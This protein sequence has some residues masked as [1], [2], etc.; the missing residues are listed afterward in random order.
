M[1]EIDFIMQ[2]VK[3]YF[4]EKFSEL[5]VEAMVEQKILDFPNEKLEAVLMSVMK[6]ELRYIE[7]I[8][9]II[10]FMIGLIQIVLVQYT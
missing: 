1:E 3:H 8:G 2:D 5:D 4:Q 10:G 7:V 6:K 9:A